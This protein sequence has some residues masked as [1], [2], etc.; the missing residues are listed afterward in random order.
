M[1]SSAASGIITRQGV[2]RVKHLQIRTLFLQD[3]HRQETISVHPVGT[4]ENTA[5]IGTRPLSAKRIKLLLHWLGFQTGD[6]EPVGKEELKE[7]RSQ[8]QAK[9]AVRMI[10][11]K[12]NLSFAALLFA[13]ISVISEGLQCQSFQQE[14]LQE[15]S[16]QELQEVSCSMRACEQEQFCLSAS[17]CA[18]GTVMSEAA[19][20]TCVEMLS[21]LNEVASSLLERQGV[22]SSKG[23]TNPQASLQKERPPGTEAMERA[24]ASDARSLKDQKKEME[25]LRDALKGNTAQMKELLSCPQQDDSSRTGTQ[26][27][28]E[29]SKGAASRDAGRQR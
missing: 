27:G 18:L 8:A 28:S 12:G 21:Q 5:D 17:A 22:V 26:R 29:G 25:Q 3:L 2:G 20:T 1:D 7:H 16:F 4:K 15:Q 6:N 14:S 19:G 11:S 24:S 13:G 23:S 9:A 10:K